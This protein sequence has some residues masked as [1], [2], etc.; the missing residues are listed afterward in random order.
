[1]LLPSTLVISSAIM[2]PLALASLARSTLRQSLLETCGETPQLP[3]RIKHIYGAARDE[4]AWGQSGTKGLVSAVLYCCIIH[5][6]LT[7][8]EKKTCAPKRM[9]MMWTNESSDHLASRRKNK[10]AP[11]RTHSDVSTA[12]EADDC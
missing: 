3:F 1:M 7:E 12:G 5:S 2:V 6:Y 4:L 11:S 8:L 10:H 9:V